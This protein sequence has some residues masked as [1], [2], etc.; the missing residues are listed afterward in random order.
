M[1][2]AAIVN[3]FTALAFTAAGCANLFNVGNAEATFRRWGYPRGWRLLTAGLEFTGAALLLLPSMRL[4]ALGGLTLVIV[5]AFVTLLR[6][7][8]G[9]SHVVAAIGFFV[10]IVADAALHHAGA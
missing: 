10:M 1:S 3:G 5:A 6:K 4:I 2:F 9:F 8:E 7:R